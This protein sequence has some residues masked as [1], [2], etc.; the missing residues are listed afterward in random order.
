MRRGEAGSWEAGK[1]GSWEVGKL[2]SWEAGKL[3][4]CQASISIAYFRLI[5]L[6][7]F[8]SFERTIYNPICGNIQ[9]GLIK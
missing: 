1:M 7:S 6:T 4:S 3:G 8:I 2:G 5:G 9:G